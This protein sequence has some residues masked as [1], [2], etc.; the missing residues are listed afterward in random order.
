MTTFSIEKLTAVPSTPTTANTLFV[1]A[2]NDFAELYFSSNDGQSLKR[3]INKTDITNLIAEHVASSNRPVIVDNIAKR[4]ELENK[5]AVYVKDATGDSTVKAG[6]A[7]YLHDG[8]AWVKIAEAESM[9]L[10]MTWDGLTG[11]PNVSV[12][13]LETAANQAHTHSNKSELDKIGQDG[14]GNLT[15]DGKA[16]GGVKMVANW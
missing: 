6:G 15:Y 5:S 13:Q 7:F 1:V 14:Q 10:T 11:K 16:V 9:D 2:N 12:T 3:V 4:D 8:N